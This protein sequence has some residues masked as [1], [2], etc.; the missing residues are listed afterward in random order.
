MHF[1][2]SGIVARAVPPL[3]VAS[4]IANTTAESTAAEYKTPL[5][6]IAFGSCINTNVHPMLDRT[7]RV[8]GEGV[9]Q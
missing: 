1:Q 9:G 8:P 5:R 3:L 6:H 2:F 4:L 7:L